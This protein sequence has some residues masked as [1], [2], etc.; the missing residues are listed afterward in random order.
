MRKIICV[1]EIF[2]FFQAEDGIRD[3]T[4]TGVQTCA[5]PICHVLAELEPTVAGE[6]REPIGSRRES[7]GSRNVRRVPA[8]RG[9]D[10]GGLSFLRTGTTP[11]T[12]GVV[13][14]Q[15]QLPRRRLDVER[16]ALQG[17]ALRERS[18]LGYEQVPVAGVELRED[19]RFPD[20]EGARGRRGRRVDQ[21]R[22]RPARR[23]GEL[24]ALERRK[25]RSAA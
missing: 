11:G 2:F 17:R 14:T 21:R 9:R 16:E 18:L 15:A 13:D 6:V 8:G 7:D 1:T 4:V 25:R 10:L 24:E 12:S 22:R 20:G 19:G 23:P 5:L 3:L